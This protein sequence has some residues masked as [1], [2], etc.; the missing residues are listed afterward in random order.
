MKNIDVILDILK[1]AE[2]EEDILEQLTKHSEWEVLYHLSP[3]RKNLLEWYDFQ[4]TETL[5]EIGAEC[6]ALTGLFCE[7]LKK[8]VSVDSAEQSTVNAIR[9]RKYSNL[10]I[11]NGNVADLPLSEKFDYVTMIGCLPKAEKYYEGEN[12]YLTMLKAAKSLLK[13]EGKLILAI[14]NKYGLKYWAGVPDN[15]F[16]NEKE[17]D[18]EDSICVF[19]KNQL[20]NLLREAGFAKQKFYYPIPD[21]K[22]PMEIYSETRLPRFGEIK[23]FSPSYSCDRKMLFDEVS[24]LNQLCRDG[25]FEQFANSFLVIC[26]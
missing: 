4:K 2:N 25:M 21:Y 11:V 9:N 12:S 19:A 24:V 26:K 13:Q 3:I 7:R 20:E 8:V 23:K 17:T 15:L 18:E 1:E 22:L 10:E 5:L 6:G 16:D 14:D